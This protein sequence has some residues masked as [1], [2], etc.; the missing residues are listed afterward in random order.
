MVKRGGIIDVAHSLSENG[1]K[2][3]KRFFKFLKNFPRPC[4][5][6]R[7]IVPAETTANYSVPWPV[8]FDTRTEVLGP[9]LGTSNV[10]TVTADDGSILIALEIVKKHRMLKRR[11]LNI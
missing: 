9:S 5:S 11:C 6:A 7:D 10:F 4:C 8:L 2:L 1:L 3:S